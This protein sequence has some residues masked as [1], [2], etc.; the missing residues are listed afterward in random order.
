[1]AERKPGPVKPPVIDLKARE[2]SEATA[3]EAAGKRASASGRQKAAAKAAR[4]AEGASAAPQARPESE[5]PAPPEAAP[6]RQDPG[7]GEAAAAKPAPEPPPSPTPPPPRPPARLAM[8]W[9]AIS[10]AAVAGA[11]LGAGLTYLMANWIALPQQ[12]PPFDDPGPALT[13]LAGRAGT[14]ETRL[15]AAEEAAL[16]TRVSLD[17][18]LVQLDTATRDLR[19]SIADVQAAIPEPQPPV[20]LSAIEEQVRAL[21]GRVAAL[22]A[23]ASSGEAAQ[24][25]ENL[26]DIQATLT[27]LGTR[28][29][30]LDSAVATS[31]S[32]IEG[33]RGEVETAKAAI[34]A[35]ATSLAGA[36]IGPAV[37]LPLI[38]S[39]LE[40]AF[41][42]GRPYAAELAGLTALLPDLA[43]PE[44]VAAHAE[45]GLVRPDALVARF[46]TALPDIIAG[47][48]GESTGDWAQDAVEW[49]KALLALRPAEEMEGSTPEAI[50]SRLEAA[51]KRRDFVAAAA[52]LAQLPAP[53]RQAAGEVGTEIAAH[54][55]ASEFV[56]ALRAQALTAAEPGN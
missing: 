55:Q 36:D 56:A 41:G 12:A 16:D 38:V 43:V 20:D 15:A 19:Q 6:P 33:L 3:E 26:S 14:L 18:T 4:A 32:A 46:E 21:E 49:A 51:M 27:A 2:A 5:S 42:S 35:Q 30:E 53:M 10:V 45:A 8:P 40:A 47:R 52:L 34:A 22:G 37:R 23:G 31:G 48:I 17:A 13:A 25:A 44:P 39:G 54:A 1:M 28:L 11:L 7:P 50:V 29:D 9:S 24:L